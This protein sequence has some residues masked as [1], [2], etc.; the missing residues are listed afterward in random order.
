[1]YYNALVRGCTETRA[2]FASLII[3][4]NREHIYYGNRINVESLKPYYVYV[5]FSYT[6]V[7]AIYARINLQAIDQLFMYNRRL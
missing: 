6:R 1:M 2:I 5:N 3:E 7:Q 4:Q